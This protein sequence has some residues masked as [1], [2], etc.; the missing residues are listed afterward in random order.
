MELTIIGSE[1]YADP[2]EAGID[3]IYIST[4]KDDDMS[5]LL[6]SYIIKNID[7]KPLFSEGFHSSLFRLYPYVAKKSK[8]GKLSMMEHFNP[9]VIY[10]SVFRENVE[11]DISVLQR[12]K[13]GYYYLLEKGKSKEIQVGFF[14]NKEAYEY[15]QVI[16]TI[17]TGRDGRPK[18]V[19][20]LQK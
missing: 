17:S 16:L 5:F 9:E 2:S 14:V 7:A 3:D 11:K 1:L 12:E 15:G 18:T 13:E 6:V 10:S 4:E 8:V 19:L 20:E